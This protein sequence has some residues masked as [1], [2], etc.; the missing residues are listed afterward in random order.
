MFDLEPTSDI[1]DPDDEGKKFDAIPII[2]LSQPK[3]VYAKQVGD[4]CRAVGFFY[5]IN[6][7][8]EQNVIDGMLKKS[9]K[10]FKL[11]AKSKSEVSDSEQGKEGLQALLRD[12]GRR[13][14]QQGRYA[15]FS[16]GGGSGIR[17]RRDEERSRACG[18]QF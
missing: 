11:D 10:V 1:A 8:V 14:R 6:H 12:Q 13:P 2:Y 3:Y 5:V 18:R 16:D 4:A 15:R 7:G 9:K 17:S